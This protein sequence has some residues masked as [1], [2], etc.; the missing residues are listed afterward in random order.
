[1]GRDVAAGI[2]EADALTVDSLAARISQHQAKM[3]L[4][5]R[6]SGKPYVMRTRSFG[7]ITAR[8]RYRPIRSG[9][10]NEYRL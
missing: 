10:G 5:G 7:W 8:C 6:Q 4:A 2:G 3:R 9:V 1:M